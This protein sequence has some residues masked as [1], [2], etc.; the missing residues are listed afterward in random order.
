[1]SAENIKQMIHA[2]NELNYQK[3]LNK[4]KN[5]EKPD[6]KLYGWHDQEGFDDEPSGWMIEGGEEA[7]Y[8]ALKKWEEQSNQK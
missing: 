8:E 5:M 3:I 4:N 6:K 1:M 2:D 7:Y